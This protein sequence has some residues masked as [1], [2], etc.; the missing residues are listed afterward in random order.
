MLVLSRRPN[1]RLVL[2]IINTSIQIVAI[3]PGVV[4]IGIDAPPDVAVFREEVLQQPAIAQRIATEI[5]AQRAE[6]AMDRELRH[7]LRNRLNATTVGLALLRK[8]IEI[9]QYDSTRDTLDRLEFELRAM[10]DS[11]DQRPTPVPSQAA[12]TKP[13]RALIVEDDSNERELLAGFLR[14]AGFDVL[15]ARD[16]QDALECL[17]RVGQPDVVL[18][19][20]ILP[21]YDG[22]STIRAIRQHP[23]WNRVK[24]C[25]MTGH[26]RERFQPSLAMT[27]IDRWYRKPLDPQSLLQD[28]NLVLA[29]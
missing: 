12:H 16:G 14:L 4:R 8:Q 17:K 3:K 28:L 13:T 19:D 6:L 15:T 27:P 11:L 7:D 25:A 26:D 24:I 21:R 1:Q 23:D 5:A 20:M 9:G 22:P 29:G 18:I 10:R 2:P